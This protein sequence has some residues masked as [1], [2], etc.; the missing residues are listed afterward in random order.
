MG[1][2]KVYIIDEA[3]MLTKEAFN[4]LLK[5][6]EEPPPNTL[7]VLC[8][9]EYDKIM[10]TIL[11][12][13]QRIIFKRVSSKDIVSYL[14]GI[15]EREGIEYSEEALEIIARLSDGSMRDSAS[16][17]DQAAVYSD[18]R[19]T[20]DSVK[21]LLG[22]L[23][24]SEVLEFLKLL[25]NSK[26]D[27]ALVLLDKLYYGGYNLERF[28]DMLSAE[29]HNIILFLSMDNPEGVLEDTDVY[30]EFGSLPLERL[31]YLEEVIN[32]G[33]V[34]ARSRDSLSAYRL[35]IIKSYIVKDIL[36]LSELLEAGLSLGERQAE[37]EDPFLRE[38]LGR[39]KRIEEGG[40][41]V[42]LFEEED[43]KMIEGKLDLLKERFPEAE[44]RVVKKKPKGEDSERRLF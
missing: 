28:W 26:V 33:K 3:H 4:A 17:L 35:A 23:T 21:E 13:C 36:A 2:Y 22:I 12:R 44:F 11:S 30:R 9:T 43:Y 41:K 24:K 32:R 29:V 27:E 14:K 38:A 18:S 15:C 16:L 25:L 39:A 8:T 10:P 37:Q 5:T 1:R 7:F 6:L 34:E 19:I 42:F 31:L 20:V 40:K